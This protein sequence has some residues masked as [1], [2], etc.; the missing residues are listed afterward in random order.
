ML[1]VMR[2][3]LV[4]DDPALLAN[5]RNWLVGS[6]FVVD[7]A[8][9]S[10]E[11]MTA[12]LAATYDVIVLDVMLG[13]PLDGYDLCRRLRT[14]A[15]DVPII[16]LTARDAVPDRVRGLQSGA[17]DYVIK[18]F[19]LEELEARIQAHA[20]RHLVDASYLLRF[21]DIE[22]DTARSTANVAGRELALTEK[23][24]AVLEHLIRHQGSPQSQ[25]AIFTSVWGFS[26]APASNLVDQYAV[27]L[28]GK[29]VS[30]GSSVTVVARKGR[31]YVL[32]NH[33]TTPGQR[34]HDE[35]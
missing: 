17:D 20:R 8:L 13:D 7:S 5:V 4:D 30:A 2:V 22:V 28:R 26:H 9:S 1:K 16:M 29:L 32:D 31:G 11:A 35:R 34:R 3:L 21:G 19:A 33:A 6:G 27:R 10:D 24:S 14:S 15:V 18:P 25:R 23:E 12:A